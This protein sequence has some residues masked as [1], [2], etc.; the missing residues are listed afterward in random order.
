MVITGFIYY[1]VKDFH[2][3]ETSV[4]PLLSNADCTIQLIVGSKVMRKYADEM[5]LQNNV[6]QLQGLNQV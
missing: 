5:D 6:K 2:S 4:K 3:V 1:I